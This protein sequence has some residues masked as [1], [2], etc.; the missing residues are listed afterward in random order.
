MN[1]C[2]HR[3]SVERQLRQG[4]KMWQWQIQST[5]W[6]QQPCGNQ[7]NESITKAM[8]ST[9][10]R[11]SCHHDKLIITSDTEI[12]LTFHIDLQRSELSAHIFNWNENVSSHFTNPSCVKLGLPVH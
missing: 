6:L 9:L 7:S 2:S 1:G 12:L 5:P 4:T 3:H 11:N 8:L 10:G